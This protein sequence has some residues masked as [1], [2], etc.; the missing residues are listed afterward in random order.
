MKVTLARKYR[1]LFDSHILDIETVSV[2]KQTESN[3]KTW[4]ILK[5]GSAI[6][7]RNETVYVTD[8]YIKGR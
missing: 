7:L 4:W 6:G 2:K 8:H 1:G 5:D 3:G